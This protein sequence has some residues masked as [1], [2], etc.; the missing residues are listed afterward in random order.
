MTVPLLH[1]ESEA[2]AAFESLP[3]TPPVPTSASALLGN[4]K[5]MLERVKDMVY[6]NLQFWN[7]IYAPL[8]GILVLRSE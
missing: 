4:T 6:N 1:Y 5:S 8:Q 3:P 2:K 7:D